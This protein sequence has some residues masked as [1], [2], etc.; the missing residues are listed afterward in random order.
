MEHRTLL[1]KQL[2]NN[3]SPAKK[4]YAKNSQHEC[5]VH[6]LQVCHLRVICVFEASIILL[7]YI[8]FSIMPE[9]S[10]TSRTKMH[11][12]ASAKTLRLP[13]PSCVAQYCIACKH[14]VQ[15]LHC[16]VQ[17]HDMSGLESWHLLYDTFFVY[18]ISEH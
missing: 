10:K 17:I 15:T 7:N 1:C 3:S 16:K 13:L 12:Y 2:Q 4:P 9:Q 18:K 6:V 14:V 11:L 8:T 5:T